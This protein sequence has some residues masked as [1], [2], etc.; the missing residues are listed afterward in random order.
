[1]GPIDYP[2]KNGSGISPLVLL[3]SKKFGFKLSYISSSPVFPNL[4]R[5][6]PIIFVLDSLSLSLSLSYIY[7]YILD[8]PFKNYP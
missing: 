1:M 3:P 2:R 7:I 6:L 4:H 8:E 5:W